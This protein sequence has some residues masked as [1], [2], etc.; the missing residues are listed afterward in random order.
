MYEDFL[1]WARVA[2]GDERLAAG[3][4]AGAAVGVLAEVGLGVISASRPVPGRDCSGGL[5]TG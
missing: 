5:I 1:D 3:Q 4:A 2:A